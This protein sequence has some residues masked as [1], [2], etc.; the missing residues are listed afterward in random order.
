MLFLLSTPEYT[1]TQKNA[2]RVKVHLRNG[3]AEIYDKHQDLMGK[4]ENNFVEV[5]TVFENKSEKF[6][7][8]V[9]EGVFVVSNKGLENDNSNNETG[10]YLYAK[11]IYEMGPNLS[12]D[13]LSELYDEKKAQLDN[14]IDEVE[15]KK[16]SQ[17]VDLLLNSRIIIL[18][19]DVE[20]L[21]RTLILLKD[22]K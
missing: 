21:R 3:V 19:E 5:E 14:K 2:T 22:M 8:I 9:Q 1:T 16:D 7:F 12:I 10:V 4:V 17:K 15:N 20:F 6:V 18:Q 13:K 11:K